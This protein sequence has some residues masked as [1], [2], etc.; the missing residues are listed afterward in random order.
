[1]ILYQNLFQLKISSN[2]LL[3][4]F[5]LYLV[6]LIYII[7]LL[8]YLFLVLNILFYLLRNNLD[9]KKHKNV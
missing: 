4:I 3:E 1:M 7:L 9:L 6:Y 8:Y 5:D 2:L